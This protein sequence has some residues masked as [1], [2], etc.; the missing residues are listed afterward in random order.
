MGI[1]TSIVIAAIGAILR[2]ATNVHSSNF[3]IQT[4]GDILMWAGAVGFV[5]S[6]FFW[7]SWGGFGGGGYSRR[8][9]V[10]DDAGPG[11]GRTYPQSGRG[12]RT[13]VEE[14]EGRY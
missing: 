11:Y 2:F 7:S 12:R 6:L 3:N 4:I 9:R 14:D 5:V 8:R 10:Y 1:G 13:V